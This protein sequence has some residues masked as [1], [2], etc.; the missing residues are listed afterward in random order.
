M[1]IIILQ[2]CLH[3][4]ARN[5]LVH[6]PVKNAAH[7]F[8]AVFLFYQ[9]SFLF[10]FL[11]Y[12]NNIV[13]FFASVIFVTFFFQSGTG[14]YI[15]LGYRTFQANSNALRIYCMPLTLSEYNKCCT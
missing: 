8:E 11:I 15:L 13:T 7:K 14:W 1:E 10:F 2:V 5:Y 12:Y 3:F 6:L 9:F 4:M